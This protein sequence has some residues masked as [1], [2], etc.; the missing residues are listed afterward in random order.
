MANRFPLIVDSSGV[1]ALKELPSGDNLDLTGNGIVGAGTVALT[2]LTVGGSQGTDGQVLTSTGSG[3]AWEDAAS[4]GGGG[5]WNVISTTTV[6]SNVSSVSLTLSGYDN[7][8]ILFTGITYQLTYGYDFN[9][10]EFSTDNGSNFLSSGIDQT[11]TRKPSWTS[12]YPDTTGR[13]NVSYVEIGEVYG[14]GDNTDGLIYLFNNVA[15]NTRK[16]GRYEGAKYSSSGV[17]QEHGAFM[18]TTTP[19]ITTIR[20]RP[21]GNNNSGINGG[22]FV[23][24]GLSTS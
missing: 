3:V 2:N 1:A 22:K 4:G 8:A 20:Y 13:S 21:H 9:K 6:S 11:E 18:I 5:A 17:M 10:W 23:L 24:Y 16:V 19:V 12:G 7:Y 15:G 14:S